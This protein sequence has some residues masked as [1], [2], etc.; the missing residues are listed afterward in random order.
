MSLSRCINIFATVV[1]PP[2]E[3]AER[4][5]SSGFMRDS[6][7]VLHLFAYPLELLLDEQHVALDQRVVRLAPGGVRLTQH[8]LQ[9]ESEPLA[10]RFGALPADDL[11]EGL[12]VRPEPVD[13][14][15]HVEPV[16]ENRDLLRHT[17]L[18]ERDSFR[19]DLHVL[20]KAIPL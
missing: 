3:G 6:L 4:T 12:H 10:G 2:P 5:S 18:V 7:D 17:L 14:L 13:L 9:D 19:Q 1:L 15:A 11:P 8:L 16:R 20:A